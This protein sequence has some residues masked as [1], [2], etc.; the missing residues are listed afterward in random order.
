MITKA[1]TGFTKQNWR[2]T[3]LQNLRNPIVY[4]FP[5]RQHVPYIQFDLEIYEKEDIKC[6]YRKISNIKSKTYIINLSFTVELTS[7]TRLTQNQD[8]VSY[9]HTLLKMKRLL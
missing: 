3:C 7:F 9:R 8:S 5:T 1:M 6:K 2:V 4:V